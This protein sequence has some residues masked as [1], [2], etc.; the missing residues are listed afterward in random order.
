MV[1]TKISTSPDC[2]LRTDLEEEFSQFHSHLVAHHPRHRAEHMLLTN[3]AIILH[4]ETLIT[5]KLLSFNNP[6]QE[7]C[8]RHITARTAV[9][10]LGKTKGGAA[11]A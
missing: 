7:L 11:T 10:R 8:L 1:I 5:M 6:F 4:W 9:A 3:D 2:V